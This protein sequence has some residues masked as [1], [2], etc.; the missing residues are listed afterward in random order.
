MTKRNLFITWSSSCHQSSPSHHHHQ[1]TFDDIKDLTSDLKIPSD[2]H[3]L[4]TILIKSGACFAFK[5]SLQSSPQIWGPDVVSKTW[6][7]LKWQSLCFIKWLWQHHFPRKPYWVSLGYL[8][9]VCTTE[10]VLTS[11]LLFVP[12]ST[13]FTYLVAS[14][15]CKGRCNALLISESPA[16]STVSNITHSRY[17]IKFNTYFVAVDMSSTEKVFTVLIELLRGWLWP[18]SYLKW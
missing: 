6:M 15:E 12:S 11:M 10:Q 2:F 14:L 5:W 13:G 1:T 4:F 17:S 9:L 8:S 3:P 16:S 18:F 7:T